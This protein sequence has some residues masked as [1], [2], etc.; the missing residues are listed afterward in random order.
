MTFKRIREKCP[1]RGFR[2]EGTDHIHGNKNHT[3]PRF[4]NKP[5]K[6]IWGGILKNYK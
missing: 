5:Y 3:D 4:L 1:K 2:R 6:K